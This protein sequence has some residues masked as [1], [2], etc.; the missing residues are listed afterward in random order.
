LGPTAT[1]TEP[2]GVDA[3][4]GIAETIPRRFMGKIK[5]G[6][7]DQGKSRQAGRRG[8][9]ADHHIIDGEVQR[10]NDDP[11]SDGLGNR[12]LDRKLAG[13]GERRLDDRQARPGSF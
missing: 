6:T 13:N 9:L 7:D 4:V 3:L 12:L 2:R 11:M 10:R 1:V 8:D 5:Q